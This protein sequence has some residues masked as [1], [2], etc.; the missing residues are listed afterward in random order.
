LAA[1]DYRL[2]DAYL[3]PPGAQR[4]ALYVEKT[5]RLP[6][7][8]WCYDPL[9]SVAAQTEL[10][11]VRRGHVTFGCLNNFAKVTDATLDLWAQVM[12]AVPKSE[13]IVLAPPG[14]ARNQVTTKLAAAGIHHSRI[15]FVDRSPRDSYLRLYN[16][17]D[18]ALDTIPYTGHTTTLDSLW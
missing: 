6:D 17:I 11:A 14:S 7:T 10:P 16:D 13:L 3:D 9:S 15:R 1:I 4:D 12:K 18:I 2:S 8:F 5:I